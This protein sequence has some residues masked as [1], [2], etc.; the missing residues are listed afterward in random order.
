MSPCW[1]C[2]R[3]IVIE[4]RIGRQMLCACNT[5]LH[6]CKN[7]QDWDTR[8]H[9]QCLEPLAEFVA[10]RESGNFCSYFKLRVLKLGEADASLA[11]KEKLAS[12]F[13]GLGGAVP[14]ASPRTAD[15]AKARLERAFGAA[16]RTDAPAATPDSDAKM[17]LE[18]LFKK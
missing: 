17:R 9:N 11:A 15:D 10:D 1:R 14:A 5:S 6:S 12:A 4:G 7:C 8:A 16:G 3:E 13:A 2:G 18:D